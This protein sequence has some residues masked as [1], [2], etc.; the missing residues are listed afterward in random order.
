MKLPILQ[1]PIFELTIPS[2]KQQIQYRPFVVREE[3]I[4]LIAQ[5]SND[6]R[7]VITAIQ[8]VINNCVLTEGFNVQELAS[9]DLEYIFLK[10]RAKSVNNI[11]ELTYK[12]NEDDQMYTFEVDLDNVD[13]VFPETVP[14]LV[15][16]GQGYKIKLRY[17]AA[18]VL[19]NVS[20]FEDDNEV[21]QMVVKNSIELL[22][23]DAEVFKFEDY[24]DQEIS[25]FV[26][27]LP[28]TCFN[29]VRVFIDSTPRLRHEINYTNKL[30]NERKILLQT[31]SD[32]FTLR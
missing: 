29:E 31:L 19:Q 20:N 9:F 25:E 28:V 23:N 18:S 15:D 27:A 21:L 14:N 3:K 26:D 2:T 4:L 12:D 1:H 24:S 5:S 16:V 11:V 7:D 13:I 6:P 32:F 8:Q 10:L 17:P 22:F 30:G